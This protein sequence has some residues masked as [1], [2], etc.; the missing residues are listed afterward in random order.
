M[1]HD[2]CKVRPWHPKDRDV[3]TDAVL[4]DSVY[5]RL[6]LESARTYT[7]HEKYRPVPL[8][9][10]LRAKLVIAESDQSGDD[11]APHVDSVSK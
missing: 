10:H 3:P 5:E 4:H 8:R 6:K 1:M 2:E 9:N 11:G 7:G